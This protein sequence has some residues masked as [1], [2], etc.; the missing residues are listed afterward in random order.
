LSGDKIPLPARIVS[1]ADCFDA[2]TSV[3]PYKQAWTFEETAAEMDR[4]TGENFDPNLMK[5]FK[6]VLPEIWKIKEALPD[7]ER[8]VSNIEPDEQK[9]A[10]DTESEKIEP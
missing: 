6:K 1:I 10:S 4:I 5:S 8:R 3:R 2:L 9:R 7:E